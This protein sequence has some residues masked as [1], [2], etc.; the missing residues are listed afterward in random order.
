VPKFPIDAPLER[1]IGALTQ[2]GFE[3]VRRGNHVSLARPNADGTRT[4]M[5]IPAHGALKSSTLRTALA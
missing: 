5:T 4:T 3:L 2:L 1:V